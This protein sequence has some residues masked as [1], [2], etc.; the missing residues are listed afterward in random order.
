MITLNKKNSFFTLIATNDKNKKYLEK[1]HLEVTTYLEEETV[2][3]YFD[4]KVTDIELGDFFIAFA[5]SNKRNLN[6][7]LD[8]FTE[9]S[10]IE[11][12]RLTYIILTTLGVFY[13][14][15]VNLKTDKTE[16]VIE[17]NFVT[18][19][20][21]RNIFEE[22]EVIVGAME[23]T[24]RLQELPFNF[25][26]AVQF[27]KIV[28]EELTKCANVTIQELN[29]K[30]I[31]EL[32]MGLLLG[33]NRGSAFEPRVLIIEYKGNSKSN[34][35]TVLV[36]K[37][38]TFDTGGYN[39]K[40]DAYMK[41]MKFD[42]GGAAIVAHTIL[43]IS[44]LK[45]KTNFTAVCVLTDNS[46][47]P[48]AFRC[49]DVLT[50][51]SGKTVEITNTDAEGRLILADGVTYAVQKLKATRVITIATL[52]GA[53]SIALGHEYTGLFSD[54]DN[55]ATDFQ[56]AAIK[57]NE[58]IW[59]MPLSDKYHGEKNRKS[60][61][62]DILQACGR[63]ASSSVAAA[64]MWQF[65]EKVPYLHLDIAGTDVRNDNIATS[66]MLKSFVELAKISEN[67]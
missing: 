32:E 28:K 65:T 4:K 52:T 46:I 8:S 7:N 40:P 37:G 60:R 62:A 18:N 20:D 23:K 30:D 31:E 38:I 2:C 19:Q 24:R 14:L 47:G 21:I 55:L 10:G 58:L 33:V 3:V 26:N 5:T 45:I 54:N 66:C 64:F 16:K 9:L 13:K 35:K 51:M 67:K 36:G 25:L 42:M 15:P 53:I 1:K 43:A 29:K 22:C 12:G 63:E 59:R 39:I 17:Y 34:E 27:T 6:V 56:N 41:N 49:D 11:I 50:S 44:N 48:D 57:A 61:I